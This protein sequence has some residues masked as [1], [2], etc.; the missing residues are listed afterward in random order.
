MP[1]SRDIGAEDRARVSVIGVPR[2]L[3]SPGTVQSSALPGGLSRED[4]GEEEG[5]EEEEGEDGG[6]G[7]RE[8]E[9]GVTHRWKDALERLAELEVEPNDTDRGDPLAPVLQIDRALLGD[10][11]VPT[12]LNYFSIVELV[13]GTRSGRGFG[14][15]SPGPAAAIAGGCLLANGL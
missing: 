4:G 2:E 11:A 12:L 9:E 8:K 1:C 15:P 6:E 3:Q 5:E 10:V 7:K 14:Q 13:V